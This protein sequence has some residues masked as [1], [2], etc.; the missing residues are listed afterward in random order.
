MMNKATGKTNKLTTGHF[1]LRDSFDIPEGTQVEF[2]AADCDGNPFQF[3]TLTE[4]A[5]RE[6]SGNVH[7]SAH[8][9]V[10]V[11]SDNVTPDVAPLAEEFARLIRAQ[12]DTATLCEI[13]RRNASPDYAAV[14]ATHDFCDANEIMAQAWHNVMRAGYTSAAYW[15]VNLVN[16]AWRMARESGFTCGVANLER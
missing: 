1:N 9:F 13:R 11:H 2:G 15:Q 7:D 4:T 5:A 16:A 6:L 10:V 14:C 12:L 3:W 8:R